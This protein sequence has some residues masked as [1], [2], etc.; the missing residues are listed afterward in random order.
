MRNSLL[1]ILAIVL[2]SACYYPKHEE[3]ITK[4]PYDVDYNFVLDADSL[5]LQEERPMHLLIVP[6]QTDSFVV[7]Y[8]D[9]LVVAQMEVIPEDSIDSVWVK[10]ARDQMTQGW[11]REKD[12]LASVVPDDPISQGIHLFSSNHILVGVALSIVALLAW[13]VRRMRRERFH[14]VH[15][16]D[17]ASPYPLALCITLS[18]SAV[19][20]ASIQRFVPETWEEFYFH[21]TLNPFGLPLILSTFLM[22]VWLMLVLGLASLGDIRRCLGATEAVLY[23]L[24]L[25]AVLALLYVVFSITTLYYL[26]Y[27]LLLAYVVLGVCQYQRRHKARFLCGHCGAPMHERGKCYKCGTLNE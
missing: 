14:V 7:Y 27:P 12:L 6:E 3:S 10:V 13:L 9:V 4:H 18:C 22:C 17:I 25:V 16:D 15:I 26:G 5:V 2:L 20:Y 19:L 8:D 1:F 11:V 23:T 21:P 24:M